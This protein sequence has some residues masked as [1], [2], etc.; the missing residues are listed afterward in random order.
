MQLNV[1]TFINQLKISNRENPD[2]FTSIYYRGNKLILNLESSIGSI[3][4]YTFELDRPVRDVRH[5]L[6]KEATYVKPLSQMPEGSSLELLELKRTLAVGKP[7][8]RY[9]SDNLSFLDSLKYSS[10]DKVVNEF[11][12]LAVTNEIKLG[13]TSLNTFDNSENARRY[14]RIEALWNKYARANKIAYDKPMAKNLLKTVNS[15]VHKSLEQSS[16][17][18]VVAT[19]VPKQIQAKFKKESIQQSK[20]SKQ[21]S[22]LYQKKIDN[23]KQARLEEYKKPEIHTLKYNFLVDKYGLQQKALKV[24]NE[25]VLF[26][27]K[28][29]SE[30]EVASLAANLKH[31]FG[32]Y[33]K[34]YINFKVITPEKAI[35]AKVTPRESFVYKPTELGYEQVQAGIE[36]DILEYPNYEP[37]EVEVN[38]KKYTKKPVSQRTYVYRAMQKLVPQD[39]EIDLLTKQEQHSL[40]QKAI[41]SKAYKQYLEL[42]SETLKAFSNP[43]DSYATTSWNLNRLTY[44]DLAQIANNL[45]RPNKY[46]EFLNYDAFVG[47]TPKDLFSFGT[48]RAIIKN[49]IDLQFKNSP[50]EELLKKK[51]D[52]AIKVASKFGI[53]KDIIENELENIDPKQGIKLLNN[54]EDFFNESDY[55]RKT[56]DMSKLDRYKGT[57]K[58]YDDFKS[59]AKSFGKSFTKNP[60][61]IKSLGLL[62]RYARNPILNLEGHIRKEVVDST[63]YHAIRQAHSFNKLA[64]NSPLSPKYLD[65]FTALLADEDRLRLLKLFK[66]LDSYPI[67]KQAIKQTF[68]SDRA[69]IEA[70]SKRDDQGRRAI[71]KAIAFKDGEPVTSEKLTSFIDYGSNLELEAHQKDDIQRTFESLI[72]EEQHN[73]RQAREKGVAYKSKTRAE[74]FNQATSQ[75]KTLGVFDDSLETISYLDKVF[76]T[77]KPSVSD[78]LTATETL[79]LW[80]P[81]LFETKSLGTSKEFLKPG[82][83]KRQVNNLYSE[84]MN[85]NFDISNDPK[86]IFIRLSPELVKRLNSMS[87]ST[88]YKLWQSSKGTQFDPGLIKFS[89]N[90]AEYGPL[91][92]HKEQ[93]TKLVFPEDNL[94]R[95]A[96]YR[97]RILKLL[98]PVKIKGV[99]KKLYS[100]LQDYYAS[101]NVL[102]TKDLSLYNFLEDNL[103]APEKGLEYLNLGSINPNELIEQVLYPQKTKQGVL[104]PVKDPRHI[105]EVSKT[106]LSDVLPSDKAKLTRLNRGKAAAAL[107]DKRNFSRFQAL[108]KGFFETQNIDDLLDGLKGP[109]GLTEAFS[110]AATAKIDLVA[111]KGFK[112]FKDTTF[113][114]EDF[115]ALKNLTVPE[116]EQRINDI[117]IGGKKYIREQYNLGRYTNAKAGYEALESLVKR[118]HSASSLTGFDIK[119]NQEFLFD[120]FDYDKDLL[121]KLK[122]KS[123]TKY[124]DIYRSSQPVPQL[125]S[126]DILADYQASTLR[127]IEKSVLA[128]VL[129]GGGSAFDIK[130]AVKDASFDSTS[131]ESRRLVALRETYNKSLPYADELKLGYNPEG[132]K[133]S[134]PF[135]FRRQWKLGSIGEFWNTES[136]MLMQ[137]SFASPEKIRDYLTQKRLSLQTEVDLY[138][139]LSPEKRKLYFKK[140][141]WD[142]VLDFNVLL[143]R[144]LDYP[145]GQLSYNKK[146]RP[147]LVPEEPKRKPIVPQKEEVLVGTKI[148]KPKTTTKNSDDAWS[149]FFK[150]HGTKFSTGGKVPGKGHIDEVPA[151]LTKGEV[152]LDVATSE[153]LGIKTQ[154]DYNRFKKKVASGPVVKFARGG[155]VDADKL[156]ASLDKRFTGLDFGSPEDVNKFT[157]VL[158]SLNKGLAKLGTTIDQRTAFTNAAIE[159]IMQKGKGVPT[160]YTAS[161]LRLDIEANQLEFHLKSGKA[162]DQFTDISGQNINYDTA[163]GYIS[164]LEAK[165]LNVNKAKLYSASIEAQRAGFSVSE[166][167]S[168]LKGEFTEPILAKFQNM[169]ALDSSLLKTE[170]PNSITKGLKEALKFAAPETPSLDSFDKLFVKLEKDAPL[171]KRITGIDFRGIDDVLQRAGKTLNTENRLQEF[172]TRAKA[173]DFEKVSIPK[174]T[175]SELYEMQDVLSGVNKAFKEIEH[176]GDTK[177]RIGFQEFTTGIRESRSIKEHANARAREMAALTK[178]NA[179]FAASYIGINSVQQ[180]FGN[181]LQFLGDFDDALKNLQAIT[182]DTSEGLNVMS[183]AIKQVS[184]DTK[185][186][187]LEISGAATILGQAGFSATGIQK[188]LQGNV[189]LATAT[190]SKLED[191]TQVLTSALTIWDTSLTESK[192]LAN[193][194]TA[195]INESKLDINSLAL[196]LQYAGNIAASADVSITDLV[197]STSL[198]KDAGIKRGSTLGTGQRLLISD[199]ANPTKKFAESLNDAGISIVKFQDA[200]KSKGFQGALK[201]MKE[202]GYGLASASKGM[203]VRE[204]SIY[205]ALINQL[206]QFDTFRE[207]ISGTEAATVANVV[208][209]SAI[210][211]KFKNMV[212]SWQ[213]AANDTVDNASGLFR[214]A[215]DALTIKQEKPNPRETFINLN[216]DMSKGEKPFTE[217]SL[218]GA[219]LELGLAGLVA[220]TAAKEYIGTTLTNL[221]RVGGAV[222]K[223]GALGLTTLGAGLAGATFAPEG[224]SMEGAIEAILPALAYE[225]MINKIEARNEAINQG[226]RG[227]KISGI[228]KTGLGVAAGLLVNAFSGGTESDSAWTR[229]L[230]SGTEFGV[231]GA[232]V[233]KNPLATVGSAIVGAV[234]GALNEP[235]RPENGL[236]QVLGNTSNA[237]KSLN[238][239]IEAVSKFSRQV[240]SQQNSAYKIFSED[241]LGTIE[242]KKRGV[243]S[244]ATELVD[245]IQGLEGTVASLSGEDVVRSIVDSLKNITPEKIKAVNEGKEVYRVNRLVVNEAG[246]LE[247]KQLEYGGSFQGLVSKLMEEAVSVTTNQVDKLTQKKLFPVIDSLN[248][249]KL[250]SLADNAKTQDERL[251][252]FT[253]AIK[254]IID[255]RKSNPAFTERNQDEL[256]NLMEQARNATATSIFEGRNAEAWKTVWK[257]DKQIDSFK[258]SLN[259]A[260]TSIKTLPESINY[261]KAVIDRLKAEGLSDK[262]I[263]S[264]TKYKLAREKYVD[265]ERSRGDIGYL[266]EQ[267]RDGRIRLDDFQKKSNKIYKSILTTAST[268]IEDMILNQGVTLTN[269]SVQVAKNLTALD[270]KALA[271]MRSSM[272]TWG[273]DIVPL[274]NK[275][276]MSLGKDLI[277]A[278]VGNKA[279]EMSKVPLDKRQDIKLRDIRQI[280][281]LNVNLASKEVVLADKTRAIVSNKVENLLTGFIKNVVS[282]SS[283]EGLGYSEYRLFNQFDK[284]AKKLGYKSLQTADKSRL[285][286]YELKNLSY[287]ELT[288][289]FNETTLDKLN[290][291]G[292][293]TL[294]ALKLSKKRAERDVQTKKAQAVEDTETNYLRGA[295]KIARD[296]IRGDKKIAL[297]RARGLEDINK[298]AERGMIDLRKGHKRG[299][300]DLAIAERRGW[301]DIAIATERGLQDIAIARVRGYQDIAKFERRGWQDIAIARSRGYQDISISRERG[302]Q[303]ISIARTRGYQDIAQKRKYGV[304]DIQL[305]NAR[306]LEDIARGFERNFAALNLRADRSREDLDLK[307][308]RANEDLLKKTGRALED[309]TTSYEDK[310][311][312]I[313]KAYRRQVDSLTRR[314]TYNI[315]AIKRGYEDNLKAIG[316]ARQD[317]IDFFYRSLERPQVIDLGPDALLKI[318]NNLNDVSLATNAQKAALEANT[319]AVKQHTALLKTQ[320]SIV[321]EAY[322]EAYKK[323]GGKVYND[324]GTVNQDFVDQYKLYMDKNSGKLIDS[325]ISLAIDRAMAGGGFNIT[326]ALTNPEYIVRQVSN[327]SAAMT[328][329]GA[330]TST[331]LS[332]DEAASALAGLQAGEV[333]ISTTAGVLLEAKGGMEGALFDLETSMLQFD[334]KIREAGINLGI[335]LREAAIQYN[336]QLLEA[337]ISL[338]QALEDLETSNSRSLRDINLNLARGLDDIQLAYARGLEDL[339]KAFARGLEDLQLS[340]RYAMDDLEIRTS[341]MYEDLE[342]SLTRAS[343]SL[344]LSLTRA[345]ENLELKLSRATEDLELKLIRAGEDLSLKVLRAGEDLEIRLFRSGEDLYLKTQRA[346]EDLSLRIQRAGE[347]LELSLSRGYEDLGDKLARATEDLNTRFNRAGEDL[348]TRVTEALADLEISRAQRLEDLETGIGRA[349]E[350][351]GQGVV[352]AGE[353]LKT[354]LREAAEDLR[355]SMSEAMSNAMVE[356]TT[357]AVNTVMAGDIKIESLEQ[358]INKAL[359]TLNLNA[360]L[361]INQVAGAWATALSSEQ[362]KNA[363]RTTSIQ[364]LRG[365]FTNLKMPLDVLTKNL[366]SQIASGFDIKFFPSLNVLAGTIDNNTTK[367]SRSLSSFG[368]KIDGAAKAADQ[369][370]SSARASL[371]TVSLNLE[372]I[373]LDLNTSSSLIEDAGSST[374]NAASTFLDDVITTAQETKKAAE[375]LSQIKITD[376]TKNIVNNTTNLVSSVTGMNSIAT[377]MDKVA[378]SITHT[379]NAAVAQISQAADLVANQAAQANRIINMSVLST[380]GSSGNNDISITRSNKSA[381]GLV[382]PGVYGG[383]DKYP[384]LLEAGE[385]VIRKEI[386]KDRGIEWFEALNNN[387]VT[388]IAN[389]SN[390]SRLPSNSGSVFNVNIGVQAEVSTSNIEQHI[391]QIADGVKRVFEEYS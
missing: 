358:K 212:N 248:T 96:Y 141:P 323:V 331:G 300:E 42:A 117:F 70:L 389:S 132:L 107:S 186:S 36:S 154:D 14:H 243:I 369:N 173:F 234:Y 285:G 172:H 342:R 293:R 379:T 75:V 281:A 347:D 149:S 13:K 249:D 277:T 18:P 89:T 326:Q 213:I 63:I 350:H 311:E 231:T 334:I 314:Y 97:T 337:A 104:A 203:E 312:D 142:R 187:A 105:G 380:Q 376:I 60:K 150:K 294:E 101:T 215:L 246:T 269:L 113:G 71:D 292:E 279:L 272:G 274:S 152:V 133:P 176:I 283:S 120:L 159:S 67:T 306:A 21:A 44:E 191:S 115:K 49:A 238:T 7:K 317:T 52:Q 167:E 303:D 171:L 237:L 354:K 257:M 220:G 194:F 124:L 223:Y 46:K 374:R 148:H 318:A 193:E 139:S 219:G 95:T 165:G 263:R 360:E 31:A 208:Q 357:A 383:G 2:L 65:D 73:E 61:E 386:V 305:S 135:P 262:E 136:T 17:N 83:L 244:Q 25:Y 92:Q 40:Q 229:A 264:S 276:I 227:T 155:I 6:N 333:R 338:S 183:K 69:I 378:I 266:V 112:A 290:K 364:T 86:N 170:L 375:V 160:S 216:R 3:G 145:G 184:T 128:E 178:Q 355:G 377:A 211:N 72:L 349:I 343:E 319:S 94:E 131:F 275:E 261:A 103:Y 200:F 284:F 11:T 251:T 140:P 16:I 367:V 371:A 162:L 368:A 99:N 19:K 328:T 144:E 50:E 123:L 207:S 76:R 209:M 81:E 387:L 359:Q 288:S 206:D 147:W 119:T 82:F 10:L 307:I 218:V 384:H 153:K 45:D 232:L 370:I 291:L 353:N 33:P 130:H 146:Y 363:M 241:D 265:L 197:T 57:I 129:P 114:L 80:K 273:K 78:I 247:L 381:G 222:G 287:P 56:Q 125:R 201:M 156:A 5:L 388:Q 66:K 84:L 90:K 299:M 330:L 267:A 205:L 245:N 20:N 345:G 23:Y 202:A 30:G 26:S 180:L 58:N 268:N 91:K 329:G 325:T 34:E 189:E 190:G 88:Y 256:I 47:K 102:T 38:G 143:E 168:M 8:S 54:I 228:R 315:E 157:K 280:S 332:N 296:Y 182:G 37:I 351:L 310:L 320:Q 321:K 4:L 226:A 106:L 93:L 365:L 225:G 233:S 39:K 118:L 127:A 48:R 185:F 304:E 295:Q 271:S 239:E 51:K 1:S 134:R 137:E 253:Q 41:K 29:I 217:S 110:R 344:E 278:D 64:D 346:G 68:G 252:L 289:V 340:H 158:T 9:G 192:K 221:P 163:R 255:I 204:K 151:L 15:L 59:I 98:D 24:G 77:G 196:T 116:I 390:T 372:A 164:R 169:S 348:V 259:T 85:Y 313:H 161:E 108:G 236:F 309:L 362:L 126:G 361:I 385:Y 179:L 199:F 352:D 121:T 341:R 240:V 373:G 210:G 87:E 175:V 100:E 109:K 316:R 382:A 242:L 336:Q 55:L 230:A 35:K 22:I 32:S 282:Q 53:S 301:Q 62:T 322:K 339:N 166:F 308:S 391:D 298:Q 111:N 286:Y 302:Y 224:N 254:P 327:P 297:A 356:A 174:G 28:G 260:A 270:T 188:S 122:T 198:L 74:L 138:L 335:A 214:S 258:R 27:K 177:A 366:D 79:K 43:F 195:A 250:E 181:T 235:N 12:A 324:N